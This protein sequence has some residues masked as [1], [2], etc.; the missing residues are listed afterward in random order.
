MAADPEAAPSPQSQDP[1]L[2]G[3]LS[4]GLELENLRALL[5]SYR[6]LR[7]PRGFQSTPMFPTLLKLPNSRDEQ[8]E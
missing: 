4:L 6:P 2:E 8:A 1:G 7:S 3:A 5:L